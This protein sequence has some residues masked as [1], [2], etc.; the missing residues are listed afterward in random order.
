[1][2]RY[3]IIITDD[4]IAIFKNLCAEMIPY[5]RACNASAE[6]TAGVTTICP[7]ARRTL[8]DAYSALFT[9][10]VFINADIEK[11]HFHELQ[12]RTRGQRKKKVTP[13]LSMHQRVLVD[14]APPSDEEG[15]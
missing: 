4:I 8:L 11:R 15:Q 1:M 2:L 13:D 7:T 14:E 3:G 10:E 5:I 9:A 6:R 12:D